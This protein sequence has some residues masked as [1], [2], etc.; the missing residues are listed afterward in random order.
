MGIEKLLEGVRGLELVQRATALKK[1]E[2]AFEELLFPIM[3]DEDVR[4]FLIRDSAWM[5]M[6][7]RLV[8]AHG[9]G[10]LA[11]LHEASRMREECAKQVQAKLGPGSSAQRSLENLKV[12]LRASGLG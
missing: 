3:M 10:G 8:L 11:M 1:D 9:T 5:S 12:M 4:G 6:A 7:T 2:V